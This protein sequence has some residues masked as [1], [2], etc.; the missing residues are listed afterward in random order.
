MSG[1]TADKATERQPRPG[2]YNG[3]T[4]YST[5]CLNLWL[6]NDQGSY[7]NLMEIVREAIK[8]ATEWDAEGE[9]LPL[10]DDAKQEAIGAVAAR[11]ESDLDSVIEETAICGMLLD[12]LTFATGLIDYREIAEN[13]VTDELNESA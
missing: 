2:E 9:D 3:W 4:N 7:D 1:D 10:D 12:L 6:S 13:L 8:D 11:L 5:W